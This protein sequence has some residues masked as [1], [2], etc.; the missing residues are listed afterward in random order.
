M[1]REGA[2]RRGSDG[3]WCGCVGGGAGGRDPCEPA[4]PMRASRSIFAGRKTE[5]RGGPVPGRPPSL[6]VWV[7]PQT[8]DEAMKRACSVFVRVDSPTVHQF[9]FF[10]S[11]RRRVASAQCRVARHAHVL[12]A[13]L[14]MTSTMK[15]IY[16]ESIIFQVFE[17][18]CV[19]CSNSPPRMSVPT[20]FRVNGS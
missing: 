5:I 12:I 6:Q 3:A 2:D 1:G 17:L 7:P 9:F 10:R 11:D 19:S 18:L 20:M 14:E 4:E 16:G 13:L 15:F 8:I